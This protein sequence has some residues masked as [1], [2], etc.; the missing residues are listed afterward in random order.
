MA[1]H[2][3]TTSAEIA[4]TPE[5]VWSILLDFAAYPKWNPFIRTISG[6]PLIGN[7]LAVKIQLEGRRA[8]TFRP[9]VLQVTEA[10]QLRWLGHLGMPGLFDREHVF[11]VS[12]LDDGKIR[13]TQS[14]QFSG[15]LAGMILPSI[16]VATTAGFEAMN[17]ALKERAEAGDFIDGDQQ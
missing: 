2:E 6:T 3:I 15:L 1:K 12:P 11:A 8:M 10:Q 7:R 5:R 17:Q 13:F 9:T 4:A 14:E 16:K